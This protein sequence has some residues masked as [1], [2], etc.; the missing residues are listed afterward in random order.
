MALS[1]VVAVMGLSANSAAVVIG[2]ML[3]APLMTPVMGVAAAVAMALPALIL[4]PL[5]YVASATVGGVFGSFLL[6]TVLSTGPLSAEL[7]SRTSPDVRDL[8][9]ALA[10]GAA[11]AYAIVRPDVSASLPGVAVAVALVP[12]LASVGLA[13]EAGRGDLARGA[14]LLYAANL[15]AIVAVA[16]VVF[17]LTGF[18]P[19]RRLRAASGRVILGG[20]VAAALTLAAAIPLAVASVRAATDGHRRAQVEEAATAWIQGTGDEI[21]EV[22]IDGSTVRVRVAGPVAPPP[23]LE[24]SRSVR[25]VLG[26]SAQVKVSWT[27]TREAGELPSPEAADARAERA[28]VEAQVEQWLAEAGVEG[29]QIDRISITENQITVDLTSA[30]PPPPVEALVERLDGIG[31]A[32][33]LIVNWTPR[34]TFVPQGAIGRPPTV[35]EVAEDLERQVELWLRSHEDYEFLRL[36]YD[37]ERL[38]ID[39]LGPAP[40]DT[41]SLVDELR[42]TVGPTSPIDVWLTQRVRLTPPA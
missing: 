36:D 15:A 12:P 11:G 28:A 31:I 41:S 42:R 22:R 16:V 9:V 8:L 39:I 7:L 2:A 25:S 29:G 32:V 30:E 3:L 19:L 1:I 33:E 14:V 13:L 37:G 4:R 40:L 26:Q 34:T 35:D 10:A 5:A 38:A 21:D 6:G 24:L 18:V 27:Q 20:A 23:T 17:V